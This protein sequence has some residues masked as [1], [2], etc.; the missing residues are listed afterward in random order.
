MRLKW[1]IGSRAARRRKTPRVTYIPRIIGR[2][3]GC[4]GSQAQPPGQRRFNTNMPKMKMRPKIL[5]TGRKRGGGG[6]AVIESSHGGGGKRG[7]ETPAH[8]PAHRRGGR[9]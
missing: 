8:R 4:S 2:Y 7:V 9:G 6:G 5:K 1:R 3:A